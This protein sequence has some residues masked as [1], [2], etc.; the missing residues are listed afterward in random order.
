MSVVFAD[1][2]LCPPS[3]LIIWL[4]LCSELK[5]M[6]GSPWR[7]WKMDRKFC[8]QQVERKWLVN[9]NVCSSLHRMVWSYRKCHRLFAK[10]CAGNLLW[11][12]KKG[13]DFLLCEGDVLEKSQLWTLQFWDE[14][15][16]LLMRNFVAM[17]AGGEGKRH[18]QCTLALKKAAGEK[19]VEL[20][21]TE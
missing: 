9:F 13:T 15:G 3:W 21:F 7:R 19:S 20:I 17:F 12:R 18:G 16:I 8:E 11:C 1:L 14:L 4:S 10:S 5:L 6:V 2:W